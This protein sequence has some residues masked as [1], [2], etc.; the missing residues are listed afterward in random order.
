MTGKKDVKKLQA[1]YERLKASIAALGLVQAGT[2]TRR[3]DRRPDAAGQI[4]ERG[5]YYQW[6]FKEAG[7]TRTVNLSAEQAPLWEKAIANQR[8]LQ[9]TVAAMHATSLAILRATTSGVAPRTA[10]AP[11]K[12]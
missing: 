7:K 12:G 3:I 4:V 6:T 11:R 10:S 1:R 9:K 8:K 5:P 2:V